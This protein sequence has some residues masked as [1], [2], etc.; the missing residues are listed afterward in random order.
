M[1]MHRL[2]SLGTPHIQLRINLRDKTSGEKLDTPESLAEMKAVAMAKLSHLPSSSSFDGAKGL[3]Q[4]VVMGQS[5][6]NILGFDGQDSVSPTLEIGFWDAPKGANRPKNYMLL[7]PFR[8]VGEDSQTLI[9]DLDTQ[10]PD[11]VV[12]ALPPNSFPHDHSPKKTADTTSLAS[13]TAW[14]EN[15][16]QATGA[17]PKV[18]KG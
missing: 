9:S 11:S 2:V 12:L 10:M 13:E 6:V 15:A 4:E 14:I 3:P 1:L 7:R 5:V 18:L 8:F 17:P 16:F